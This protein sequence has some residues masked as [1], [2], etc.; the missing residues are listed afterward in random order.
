VSPTGWRIARIGGVDV[1][2][3]PSLGI[4]ALLITFNLWIGFSQG[5][6]ALSPGAA[7]AMAALTAVLFFASILIHELAHA[8]VS[9][10]RDI[11]V[12]G[13]TLWMLGGATHAKVEARGPA[14]EFLISAV[15][16]LSS[17]G[18]SLAFLALRELSAGLGRPAVGMF[19]YLADINLL[20]AIF[21][22][23]PGFPLDGG[24]ILRSALWKLTGSLDRATRW[25]A[26]AGQATGLLII[27]AGVFLAIRAGTLALALWPALIGWF[28]YRAARDSL[29]AERNRRQ[30]RAVRARDVMHPPPP[31]IPSDLSVAE[32][33]AGYLAGHPGESFPVM[34]NGQVVGFVSV[35]SVGNSVGDL[36]VRD[37]MVGTR[38]AVQAASDEGLDV[39][40]DRMRD[41]HAATVLVMDGGRVVGA[42]GFEDV[43]RYL[44]DGP[45]SPGGPSRSGTPY[46]PSR[47]DDR[48]PAPDQPPAP[49]ARGPT[50]PPPPR[51]D[52]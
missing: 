6:G 22:L 37:A 36:P 47:A 21:N 24:R 20:L 52:V 25:A 51:P 9:R 45:R 28:L 10:L 31:M 39:I 35:E 19:G 26:R 48:L 4:I 29:A 11:P 34:E 41:Q 23:L 33:M 49:G 17:V 44:T 50:W 40:L 7:A 3:D 46:R 8:G 12:L 18:L 5:F 14:D 38:A 30:I 15:G 16:P 27:A 42:F 1:R 13:I 2:I 43:E 32:A